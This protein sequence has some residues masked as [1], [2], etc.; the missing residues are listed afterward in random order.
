MGDIRR[1]ATIGD[2]IVYNEEC[3]ETAEVKKS[4]REER[5]TEEGG[6]EIDMGEM[7]QSEVHREWDHFEDCE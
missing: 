1:S 6:V 7:D 2:G 5:E 3:D 4:D